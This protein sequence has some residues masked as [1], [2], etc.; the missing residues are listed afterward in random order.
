MRISDWRSDWCA[1]DLFVKGRG[2]LLQ[3]FVVAPNGFPPVAAFLGRESLGDDIIEEF[4]VVADQQDGTRV[5][6]QQFFQKLQ[7]FNVEVVG[8]FVHHEHIRGTREKPCQHQPR[9]RSEEHT[10][11]LQSLMRISYAVFCWKKK[12]IQNTTI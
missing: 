2:S 11:E 6:L 4:P 8:G 10:S 9:P 3:P 5:V 12:T 7:S 1:S